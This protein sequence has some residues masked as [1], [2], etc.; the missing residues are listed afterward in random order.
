MMNFSKSARFVI[1][2]A[3]WIDK[4]LFIKLAILSL[5]QIIR[6]IL[7]LF[8]PFLA[9][10]SPHLSIGK[11][12]GSSYE[13][14]LSN[15]TAYQGCNFKLRGSAN[16]SLARAGF[17]YLIY[18]T[19]LTS[20]LVR[21]SAL[22]LPPIKNRSAKKLYFRGIVECSEQRFETNLASTKFKASAN[23]GISLGRWFS[24]FADNLRL[25]FALVDAFPNLQF[26]QLVDLQEPPDLSE[27]FF[28]VMQSG[29]VRVFGKSDANSIARD[30]LDI[31]NQIRLSS[32]EGLLAIAFHP[33]YA[34]NGFFFAHYIDT[35]GRGVISRFSVSA[36]DPNIADLAS[37][38]VLLKFEKPTNIH[39]G[40]KLAFGPDGYLYA[41]I[42]DGGPQGDPTRTGQNRSDLLGSVIRIDVDSS[43]AGLNYGIPSTNPFVGV[44]NVRA[45][46]FA[47]GFRNPWRFS[48]DALKGD[49]WLGDVGLESREE[50]NRVFSGGNYGWSIF[51]GSRCRV[52][53]NQCS[54]KNLIN[55]VYEYSHSQGRSVTAGYVYRGSLLPDLFGRYV[56][57]DFVS[58]SIWALHISNSGPSVVKIA[59]SGLNISS[60]AEGLA[61]E[62]YVLDYAGKIYKLSQ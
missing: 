50:I 43:M 59:E 15:S 20:D 54:K 35:E 23:N 16:S 45:E 36:T 32:E 13:I 57:G 28:A 42:G 44:P 5:M 48:F 62:L 52:L 25:K 1:C 29:Q 40:G 11:G 30:F 37:E 14:T 8:M 56:F 51:E 60:F 4:N 34:T 31:S 26:P 24:S 21:I 33:D 41:S 61:R 46:I 55:P 3:V 7:F 17:G 53:S 47:F 27:R 39:H 9:S 49:L 12:V 6:L 2:S 10:A 38:V 18:S 22:D 58:G 19:V